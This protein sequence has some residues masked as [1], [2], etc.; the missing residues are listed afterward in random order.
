MSRQRA[1]LGSG[2]LMEEIGYGHTNG[3]ERYGHTN[4]KWCH[5]EASCPLSL[6]SVPTHDP[7]ITI[8]VA[9][10]FSLFWVLFAN[11][12]GSR[13]P[14]KHGFLSLAQKATQLNSMARAQLVIIS[15]HRED[16]LKNWPSPDLRPRKCLANLE[17]FLCWKEKATQRQKRDVAKRQRS[18]FERALIRKTL[19]N[20]SIKITTEGNEL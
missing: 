11:C 14:V 7:S 8:S 10:S 5:I 15:P 20:L 16:S 19:D 2:F 4:V 3:G 6:L 1:A 13:P 12:A 18:Q 9:F 17:Y